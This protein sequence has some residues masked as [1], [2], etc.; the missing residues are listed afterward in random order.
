M[1]RIKEL[2]EAGSY[3]DGVNSV[4]RAIMMAEHIQGLEAMAFDELADELVM[5]MRFGVIRNPTRKR[6]YISGKVS[7]LDSMVVW[8]K[9]ATKEAQLMAEGVDVINP[10]RLVSESGIGDCQWETIM[11][12]LLPELLQC[13][14]LHLLPDWD[15]STGAILEKD[16][17]ERVGI[18]VVIA[19]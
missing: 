16:I 15:D 5:G 13:D 17:A 4:F 3:T 18:K 10:V 6:M 8:E 12:C 9:F 11:R 1:G 2:L 19:Q 7:G 14:E